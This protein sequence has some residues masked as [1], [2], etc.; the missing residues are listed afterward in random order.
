MKHTL[1]LIAFFTVFFGSCQKTDE[2]NFVVSSTKIG[3]IVVHLVPSEYADTA[4]FI[5]TKLNEP[6]SITDDIL[7]KIQTDAYFSVIIFQNGEY[8]SQTFFPY[9]APPLKMVIE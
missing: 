3:E 7:Q 1:L 2:E 8:V 6:F 9:S 5:D 4:F